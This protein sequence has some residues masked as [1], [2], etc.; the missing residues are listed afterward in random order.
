MFSLHEIYVHQFVNLD[1]FY[2]GVLSLRIV[3][4]VCFMSAVAT[5]GSAHHDITNGK[6]RRSV[7]GGE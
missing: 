6:A 2:L 1:F 4:F 3:L 5:P 7:S